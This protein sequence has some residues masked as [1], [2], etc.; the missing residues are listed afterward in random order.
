MTS[1]SNGKY[2]AITSATAE[3]MEPQSRPRPYHALPISSVFIVVFHYSA[4]LVL[5]RCSTPTVLWFHVVS[6]FP[7]FPGPLL[8]SYLLRT[9]N[10]VQ[11]HSD[12]IQPPVHAIQLTLRLELQ[13][14]PLEAPHHISRVPRVSGTQGRLC[15]VDLDPGDLS[16]RRRRGR[17]CRPVVVR[18]VPRRRAQG[19]HHLVRVGPSQQ[20]RGGRVRPGLPLARGHDRVVEGAWSLALEQQGHLLVDVLDQC[21]MDDWEA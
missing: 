12:S 14:G 17:R 19:S 9:C 5:A 3:K 21:E 20:H 13:D 1:P 18:A 6:F 2:P 11:S 8:R 4:R 15:A 16:P 7:S 10:L